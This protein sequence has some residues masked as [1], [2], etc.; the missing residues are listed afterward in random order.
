[1]AFMN[2]GPRPSPPESPGSIALEVMCVSGNDEVSRV[3]KNGSLNWAEQ[4]LT[5]MERCQGS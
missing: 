3:Q 1:M 2:G 5:A 4:P